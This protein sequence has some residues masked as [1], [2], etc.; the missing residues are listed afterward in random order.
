MPPTYPLE[1]NDT[2]GY[3]QPAVIKLL[4]EN[5]NLASANINMS[6]RAEYGDIIYD[7]GDAEN[8]L[9]SLGDDV[10]MHYCI[11]LAAQFFM[12]DA[13]IGFGELIDEQITVGTVA[14]GSWIEP[15][16]HGS[17]SVTVIG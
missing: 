7:T 8:P 14:D 10:Y 2:Y 3:K 17:S 4:D 13:A 6:T 5:G 15:S 16:G 1:I 12:D 11:S 9:M